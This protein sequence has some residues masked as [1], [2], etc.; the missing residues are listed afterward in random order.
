MPAKFFCTNFTVL[1]NTSGSFVSITK[2]M[3]STLPKRL[4]NRDLPSI[5]GIA[6]AAPISPKPNTRVPSD[7]TA[8]ILERHV[9]S[10]DLSSSSLI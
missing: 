8:T 5:T 2:G 10:K 4:N 1:I 6:A 3:Q 7:T 9:K